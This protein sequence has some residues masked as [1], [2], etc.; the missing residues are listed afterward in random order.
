MIDEGLESNRMNKTQPAAGQPQTRLVGHARRA[1]GWLLILATL[2]TVV[3][4]SFRERPLL[5]DVAKVSRGPMD[6]RVEEDGKTRIREKYV[7]ST[8]L[9]ARLSRITLEV[10][11]A[12]KKDV[13]V[14]SRLE[15]TDPSLLDPRAVAQATAR[16]RAAERKLDLSRSSLAKTEAKL[17]FAESETGRV[18]KMVAGNAASTNWNSRTQARLN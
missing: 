11:D 6:V 10:G 9:T 15:A 14:L 7:V 18:R 5:V 2:T 16:V 13:T 17:Q 3:A 12:V 4:L 8:P 1:L